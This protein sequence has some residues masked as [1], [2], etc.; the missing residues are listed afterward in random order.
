MARAVGSSFDRYTE[1]F[2]VREYDEDDRRP[3]WGHSRS[4][5]R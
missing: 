4:S 3:A 2:D 1:A 5:S